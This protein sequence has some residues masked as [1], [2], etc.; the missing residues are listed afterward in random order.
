MIKNA[1]EICRGIYYYSHSFQ[2]YILA[3]KQ[4]A[5]LNF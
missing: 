1:A 3:A 4:T 2:I 5:K